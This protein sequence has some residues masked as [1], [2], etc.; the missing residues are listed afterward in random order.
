M[1]IENDA[2]GDKMIRET[3]EIV[4]HKDQ[5]GELDG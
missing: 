5:I 4:E 1:G 2:Y 3:T